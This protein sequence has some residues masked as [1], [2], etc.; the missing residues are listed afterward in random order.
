MGALLALRKK[1]ERNQSVGAPP[2]GAKPDPFPDPSKRLED[3]PS[4][5]ESCEMVGDNH[6]GSYTPLA[7][8]GSLNAG[9]L[10]L[11]NP[12]GDAFAIR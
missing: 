6:D 12:P 5:S 1:D 4:Q 9:I 8:R 11:H 2:L 7:T 3:I 10:D